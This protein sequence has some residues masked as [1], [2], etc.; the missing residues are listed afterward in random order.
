PDGDEEQR[1]LH[2]A[3]GPEHA[4]GVGPGQPAQPGV[5]ALQNDG[6]DERH[7]QDDLRDAQ[8]VMELHATPPRLCWPALYQKDPRRRLPTVSLRNSRQNGVGPAA[9]LPARPRFAGRLRQDATIGL[10][11]RIES[12]RLRRLSMLPTKGSYHPALFFGL[13]LA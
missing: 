10:T 6:R 8:I 7:R 3:P 5:L 13:T 11:M 9:K 2:A 4:A 1:P 12:E